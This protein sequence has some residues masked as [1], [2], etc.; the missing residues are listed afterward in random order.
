M[1]GTTEALLLLGGAE[2]GG[3]DSSNSSSTIMAITEEPAAMAVRVA[4]GTHSNLP[5]LA[6]TTI[7]TRSRTM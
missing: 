7:W 2:T 4:E 3:V 1:G 5:A 6:S